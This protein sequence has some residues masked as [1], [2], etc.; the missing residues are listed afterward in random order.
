[1]EK[2]RKMRKF[3]LLIKKIWLSKAFLVLAS[4]INAII[5]GMAFVLYM[6]STMPKSM[7]MDGYLHIQGTVLALPVIFI[8]AV[9]VSYL[10]M[11]S[12]ARNHKDR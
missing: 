3:N 5:I 10:W 4:I 8:V 9:V 7:D 6:L 12:F 2:I 1:V 11:K